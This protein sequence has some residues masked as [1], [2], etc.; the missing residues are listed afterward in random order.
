MVWPRVLGGSSHSTPLNTKWYS[1]E[2]LII[3][4]IGQEGAG[5]RNRETAMDTAKTQEPKERGLEV[6]WVLHKQQVLIFWIYQDI[7]TNIEWHKP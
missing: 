5:V 2:T 1:V 4:F 3:P 7:R 6:T